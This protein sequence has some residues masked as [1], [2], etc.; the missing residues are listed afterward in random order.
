MFV[1]PIL[2]YSGRKYALTGR[3][4]ICFIAICSLQTTSK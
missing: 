4:R 1:I 2:V 3:V